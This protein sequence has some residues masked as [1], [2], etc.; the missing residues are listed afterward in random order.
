MVST[1]GNVQLFEHTLSHCDQIAEWARWMP[2][3]L[4]LRNFVSKFETSS[5]QMAGLAAS[6]HGG[7]RR[8]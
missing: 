3:S 7:R 2:L 4:E 6:R 8:G 1:C 5:A